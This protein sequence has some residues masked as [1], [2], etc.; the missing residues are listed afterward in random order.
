MNDLSKHKYF[1]MQKK[2]NKGYSNISNDEIYKIAGLIKK[3][4]KKKLIETNKQLIQSTLNQKSRNSN[5]NFFLTHKISLLKNTNT[6]SKFK[7]LNIKTLYPIFSEEKYR[8]TFE[9]YSSK[10]I[11]EKINTKK[12]NE[13]SISTFHSNII[14]KKDNIKNLKKYSNSYSILPKPF[15]NSYNKKNNDNNN[16]IPNEISDN[17]KNQLNKEKKDNKIKFVKRFSLLDKLLLKL[18]CPEETFEDFIHFSKPIRPVDKYK[19]FQNQLSENKKKIDKMM[20]FLDINY[21]KNNKKIQSY[22]PDMLKKKYFLT[23]IFKKKNNI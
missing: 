19:R 18:S 14:K 4:P 15:E 3:K 9:S 21:L 5:L 12:E 23:S 11:N 2:K 16:L 6:F 13:S 8:N 20:H 1:K 7:N 10:N 22:T 17:N